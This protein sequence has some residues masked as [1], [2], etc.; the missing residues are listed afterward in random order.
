MYQ[1]TFIFNG[2]EIGTFLSELL[3]DVNELADA[4]I[5]YN[6]LGIP[7]EID[8]KFS[9]SFV[10][11][12]DTVSLYVSWNRVFIPKYNSTQDGTNAL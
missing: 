4:F 3:L 6:D 8:K 1:Y 9:D 12:T 5:Q 7:V 11:K 10:I 2:F